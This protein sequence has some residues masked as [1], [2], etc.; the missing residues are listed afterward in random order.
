[1]VEFTAAK[2]PPVLV[3]VPP[4]GAPVNVIFAFWHNANELVLLV[5]LVGAVFT[6]TT[7]VDAS[8]QVLVY[9]MVAVPAA[10][11]VTVAV[12]PDPETLAVPVAVLVHVP[13]PDALVR[14][15]VA[16]THTDAVPVILAGISQIVIFVLFHLSAVPGPESPFTAFITPYIF[17]SPVPAIGAVHEISCV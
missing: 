16:P 3:H 2:P 14:V 5:T 12:E 15:V 8:P 4:V 11:P 10:T 7:T 17:T 1:V 13:V 9:E 6:V